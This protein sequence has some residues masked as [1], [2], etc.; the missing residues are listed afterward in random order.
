MVLTVN[1]ENEIISIGGA[2]D[3]KILFSGRIEADKGKTT[4]DYVLLLKTVFDVYRVRMDEIEGSIIASVVPQLTAVIAEAIQIL[5]HTH[6]RVVGPGLKT[7][8]SILIDNPAQLG[9]DL[10][11]AAVGAAAAYEG[12]VAV[13]M[14]GTATT[15]C[16]L[17]DKKQ[18]MGGIIM[19]GVRVSLDGLLHRAAQLSS[20]S[21]ER[22]KRLIAT[23]TADCLRSGVIYGAAAGIDGMLVR[24]AEELGV[25]ADSLQTVASG[26]YAG[27]II[28]HCRTEITLD[29]NLLLKGLWRIYERNRR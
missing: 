1:I 12:P 26:E 14:L 15:Y 13:V 16:V 24:I 4:L 11:A 3:G 25:D 8:L 23:N 10:V 29:E 21:L 19:P 22:P 5:T 18:Y 9:S 7:G 20:V 27:L 28:P 6:A 17:N 2:E